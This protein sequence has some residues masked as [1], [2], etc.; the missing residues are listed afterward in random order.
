MHVGSLLSPASQNTVGEKAPHY[1]VSDED[2]VGD[3][4]T[5]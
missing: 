3:Y 5:A 1:I 2:S 4:L